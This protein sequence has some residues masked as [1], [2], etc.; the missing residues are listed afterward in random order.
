MNDVVHRIIEDN[1]P[2][3]NNPRLPLLHYKKVLDD[4]D[5]QKIQEAFSSNGWVNSWV[6]GIY[7]YHHY[8]SNTHEALGISGGS[9]EVQIGGEGGPV[10][11]LEA[12]DVLVIPAGVSHKNVGAS[13]HFVCVGSYP[14]NIP[15]DMRRGEEGERPE[16]DKRISKVPLPTYDPVY[17][18]EGPIF[19]H[20]IEQQED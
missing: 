20:W 7:S 19:K 9:C 15:Y 10:F 16:V 18:D 14:L 5:P 13:E 8:H 6:N 1:G 4:Y 3:P 2:F 17:G 11:H 12:G